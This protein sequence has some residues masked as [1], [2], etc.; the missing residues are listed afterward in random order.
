M[1]LRLVFSIL[2]TAALLLSFVHPAVAQGQSGRIP[3]V[4]LPK[5]STEL[6]EDIGRRFH[7]HILILGDGPIQPAGQISPQTGGPPFPGY[8]YE[9]PA[10]LACIYRL[11]HPAD[12][13]CN[14][15]VVSTN[16]N[17]GS[18]AIAIVD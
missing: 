10:S 2:T 6:A 3:R 17:G 1:R 16:P 14:P 7:T 12:F 5:S 13:G 18:K 15:N 9:T 11:V 4:T 8:F